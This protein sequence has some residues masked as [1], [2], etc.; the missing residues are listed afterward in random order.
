MTMKTMYFATEDVIRKAEY[1]MNTVHGLRDEPQN[2][3][4]ED[5]VETVQNLTV[6]RG[7]LMAMLRDKFEM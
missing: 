5:L 3:G 6:M 1:V 4:R 7:Y 2:V